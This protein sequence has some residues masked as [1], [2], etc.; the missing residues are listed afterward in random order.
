VTD[1]LS[2]RPTPTRF[3]ADPAWSEKAARPLRLVAGPGARATAEELDRLAAGL[4]RRDEPAA[5]LARALR[6]EHTVTMA[7]IRSALDDGLTPESPA[8]LHAFFATVE[9]RPDWVDD[10]LLDRGGRA[11]RAFGLDT[12]LVLTFGSLLGGYRT[13]AA[14]EPLV[15][16][17]RLTGEETLR[18]IGE[19]TAWWR[20]V[21]APGGLERGGEGWRL[22]VH[23]RIMHGLVNHLLEQDPTWDWAKR[24]V[25]INQYD[26][27]STLGVFST[28]FM[29][30]ARLL[31]LRVSRADSAAIMHLWS[32]VGWLMGVDEEWLPRTER[33]GRK[34]LY[35]MLSHDP[36][37]DGNSI[38]LAAALMGIY[39]QSPMSPLRRRFERERGLSVATW[40]LGRAAMR[41]LGQ[42]ARLPWYAFFRIAS[43]LFWS[44]G[45]GRLPGGR[46]VLID[47]AER[48]YA[49]E[50]ARL[51]PG[52]TPHVG[53]LG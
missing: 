32:Y 33:Q 16:T 4:L 14:L 37:P 28:S 52:H 24:G 38:A 48:W 12:A 46:Q 41:D 34:V 27:A 30:H 25:P 36:P 21:T 51:Y 35:R 50:I 5:T 40:L 23:V 26:Q 1:V 18:R 39:D 13:S 3:G 19:T 10:E 31:G 15:R 11:C 17:G 49:T 29:L 44:Q 53:A 22:A 2:D 47:R 45:V 43:N 8:E 20:G 9:H 7:Q 42:P 6:E